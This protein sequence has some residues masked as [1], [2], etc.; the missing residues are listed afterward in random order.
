MTTL[1]SDL[2]PATQ[3]EQYAAP[4]PGRKARHGIAETF[5]AEPER[6]RRAA[7]WRANHRAMVVGLCADSWRPM[8]GYTDC[9]I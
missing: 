5:L 1:R 7:A 3:Q 2:P 9:L 4:A 6:I 8:L